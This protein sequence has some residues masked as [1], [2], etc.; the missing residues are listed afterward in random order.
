[1]TVRLDR[2][3]MPVRFAVATS[4]ISGL[5]VAGVLQALRTG[6]S[7]GVVFGWFALAAC[8]VAAVFWA[9]VLVSA[10][11][12]SRRRSA[13]AF[14]VTSAFSQKYFV[15]AFVQRL[16]G[17]LDRDDIDLVLK[18]PE[19]DYDASA[20]SHHL[21]RILDRQ[22]DYIG[23]IIVASE[24]HRLRD[25]LT[26]F[27]RESR[28]PV[29]FTDLEPFEQ[30]SEYPDNSAF[31]GYDT[32]ELGELAGEWLVKQLRGK[33]HPRVLIIASREHSSR[34]E[35]CARVLRA[36]FPGALITID[37]QCDFM[38]SRAYDAVN[39]HVR[40][41]GSRQCLDAIFCTNDEMA[42]GAVDAL[43]VSAPS[44]VTNVTNVTKATVVVGVDGVHEAR[45]LIDT[46][47]SPLRATVTQD[48]HRL[49]M[50]V[51]DLLAKMY[52][53]HAVPR[54]TILSAEIYEAG[55]AS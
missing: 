37:D 33:K 46:G 53:G 10:N 15:Q 16:H 42:L 28:L 51:V 44:P 54:R 43:S 12:R 4:V 32:G 25:D 49:A 3:R 45:A 48:T 29:V 39:A 47:S 19:R 55:S 41:L 27:C 34:Q 30:E 11:R 40:R 36:E 22:R 38:R 20:Q 2:D 31:I 1:M 14:L 17:A 13:R 24:V 50:S 35:R 7:E 5:I 18:V 6:V 52:R 23:G 21:R 9:V 26:A 8:G